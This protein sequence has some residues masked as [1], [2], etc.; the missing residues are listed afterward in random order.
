MSHEA[1]DFM[2]F[3]TEKI[4]PQ[5]LALSHDETRYAGLCL[6]TGL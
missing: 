6:H 5:R 4:Y 2:G 3:V 1:I